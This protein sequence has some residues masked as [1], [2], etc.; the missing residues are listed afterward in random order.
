MSEAIDK[1]KGGSGSSGLASIDTGQPGAAPS[2]GGSAETRRA[3]APP[4]PPGPDAID[5]SGIEPPGEELFALLP[6]LGRRIAEEDVPEEL[7][8]LAI[9]LGRGG[10]S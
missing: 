2:D 8:R 4:V 1:T 5:L 9:A 7:R 10:K 6:E 3:S